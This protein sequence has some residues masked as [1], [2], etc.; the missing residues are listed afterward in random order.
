M[1]PLRRGFSLVHHLR[2]YNAGME[3]KPPSVTWRWVAKEPRTG[4]WKELTGA[5]NEEDAAK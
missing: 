2:S 4:R 3:S 5:M 1:A